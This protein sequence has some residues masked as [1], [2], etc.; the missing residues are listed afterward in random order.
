MPYVKAPL[1]Q[2]LYSYD[3]ANI[4]IKVLFEYNDTKMIICCNNELSIKEVIY[5][6][7]K[8]MDIDE[9]EHDISKSDGYIRKTVNNKY[10][11]QLF[12]YFTHI[13]ESLSYLHK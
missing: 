2:F 8:I 11:R 3:F 12:P 7:A 5:K 13:D 9:I 6:I 10:F 4:I 1:K